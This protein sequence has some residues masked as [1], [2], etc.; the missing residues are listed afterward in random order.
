MKKSFL[1]SACMFS[2]TAFGQGAVSRW[3]VQYVWE[4]FQMTNVS[5]KKAELL[6]SIADKKLS[7]KI[8]C[9]TIQGNF[10][11]LKGDKIKPIKL[12]NTK[13]N[14]PEKPDKLDNAVLDALKV[15]SK[16][17]INQDKAKFYHGEK[18]VLELNR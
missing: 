1:I 11:Y 16:V 13:E 14:C 8:G 15:S 5:A 12:V 6:I 9:N 18:L 7:G 10:D 17:T 4:G 3:K 2:L